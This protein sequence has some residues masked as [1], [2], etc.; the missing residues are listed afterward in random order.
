RFDS[1]Q[2]DCEA[3][4]RRVRN[5]DRAACADCHGR[6]DDVFFPVTRTRRDVAG[7]SES[8]ERRHRNVMRTADSGFEHAAAP[9]RNLIITRYSF[10][11]LCFLM[12]ADATEFHVD[13]STRF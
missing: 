13:Y 4:A 1:W 8:R 6:I 9:D 10:D 11:P 12:P 3:D 2:V 7:Q 5:F